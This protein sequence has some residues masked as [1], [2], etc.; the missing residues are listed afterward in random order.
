V[1]TYSEN[2][3]LSRDELLSVFAHVNHHLLDMILESRGVSMSRDDE[4]AWYPVFCEVLDEVT[5][6]YG[7]ETGRDLNH[8]DPCNWETSD[9]DPILTA[10]RIEVEP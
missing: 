1:N 3:P 7:K 2:C 6:R 8:D 9:P 4:D 10:P 5:M